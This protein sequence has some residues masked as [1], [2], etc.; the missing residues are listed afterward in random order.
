[1]ATATG[2]HAGQQRSRRRRA[3]RG[4][5]DQLRAEIVVAA[6]EL[7]ASSG[8]ADDVSVRAVAD[9]V[10][11]TPPSIYLHFADKSALISAVVV[12]VFTAL[13]AAMLAAADGLTQPLEKLR[14]FGLAYVEFAIAHPQHYRIAAMDPCPQPDVDEVLASSAFEHFNA[15]VMECIEAGIF[16]AGDPVAI[17]VELWAAAHGIA[18]LM[19]AKPFLP[20]GDRRAVA[21]RML[22]AAAVGRAACDLLG[23][24]PNSK[25]VLDWLGRVRNVS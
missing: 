12:D 7:I 1:M 13:D 20:W 25:A 6:K 14:A 9:A 24:E 3:Q 10:G 11:V 8:S 21:D 17:T 4:S 2:Q 18:S 5:G 16:A 19:I 23:G 15:T 22:C